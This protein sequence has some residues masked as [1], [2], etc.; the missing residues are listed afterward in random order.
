MLWRLLVLGLLLMLL[1]SLML[2]I[3]N[4]VCTRTRN[5][6]AQALCKDI[7]LGI[8]SFQIEYHRH[9]APS[10]ERPNDD[11]HTLCEGPLVDCLLG[12]KVWGNDRQFRY[13]NVR[14]LR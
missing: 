9:P 6:L 12:V 2:I 11:F 1:G 3:P 10:N 7:T 8:K 14:E 4:R 13:W 5:T